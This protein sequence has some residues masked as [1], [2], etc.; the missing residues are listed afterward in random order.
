MRKLLVTAKL[1]KYSSVFIFHF[2]CHDM[3]RGNG[4]RQR[5]KTVFILYISSLSNFS[6]NG[7]NKM[8]TQKIQCSYYFCPK[9]YNINTFEWC[10]VPTAATPMRWVVPT[11]VGWLA[12]FFCLKFPDFA[13]KHARTIT[14]HEYFHAGSMR[15]HGHGHTRRDTCFPH[16]SPM[17]T[18]MRDVS[19]L[20]THCHI[21]N[22]WNCTTST[23]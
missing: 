15:W 22:T 20:H 4:K 10:Q 5:H 3:Q 13:R 6:I 14:W 21:H 2:I 18:D 11:A 19:M 17:L 23:V 8:C 9:I 12:G 1:Q 7:R 16:A